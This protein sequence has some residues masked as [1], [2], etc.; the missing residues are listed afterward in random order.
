[1]DT[2]A[3][4]GPGLQSSI[5]SD[6]R[7]QSDTHAETGTRQALGRLSAAAGAPIACAVR[8]PVMLDV[9]GGIAELTGS[10]ALATPTCETVRVAVAPRNDQNLRIAR[11]ADGDRARHNGHDHEHTW[12]LASFYD[13]AAL[14]APELLH[15]RMSERD[16]PVERA[17]LTGAYALLAAHLAPHLSGGFTILVE[18]EREAPALCAAHHLASVQA[19]TCAA[20]GEALTGACDRRAVAKACH[21]ARSALTPELPTGLM[22]QAG[23]LLGNPGELLQVCCGSFDVAAPLP[24]PAGVTLLGIDCGALHPQADDKYGAAYTAALMGRE[25]IARL[26]PKVCPQA[27]WDGKLAR[28]SVTDFV[29]EL[30]DRIPTKLKGIQF[31]ERFDTP[32]GSPAPVEPGVIYKVRSRAEHHI[33]EEDRV[34]QFAERM[35]RARRMDDDQPVREAGEYMYASHW[36]YGQRCGLGS[37]E[38]DLL[39]TLLRNEGP[40]QGIFGARVSG[41]GCGGTVV[42][43]LRDEP[44][45]SATVERVLSVYRQRVERTPALRPIA[46]KGAAGFTVEKPA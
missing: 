28:V 5:M 17:V 22:T 13:G 42:V 35:S 38:T 15:T 8:V 9:M 29:D 40:Q 27:R 20:L 19:A 37:I 10:L 11:V 45:A 24:L 25:I 3:T 12:P 4:R 30:R 36:S 1:M 39:V 33:Y 34:R 2:T 7:V 32:A 46:D 21:T 14:A 43:L 41:T 16:C 31:L 44:A 23:P 6:T 18:T 26:L